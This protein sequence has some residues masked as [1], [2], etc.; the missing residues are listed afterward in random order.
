MRWDDHINEITNKAKQKTW[1][2]R[3][4]KKFGASEG[5]LLELYKLFVRSG[6]EFASPLW[7]NALTKSNL[8][9]LER[10]QARI[11]DLIIGPNDLS[12]NDRLQRLNIVK[13]EDRLKMNSARFSDKMIRDPRF[14]FLFP[15]SSNTMNTRN[16]NV[17]VE[18]FCK[19]NR[20][21]Y[22]AIPSFIRAQNIKHKQ[23]V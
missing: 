5:K 18:T 3:R 13:L 11:T 7:S 12:Y 14:Q 20:M 16:K 6:I 4:L 9:Q 1:F 21:Y 15:R 10:I 19:T 17:Y 8:N 23:S 2:L 22:S